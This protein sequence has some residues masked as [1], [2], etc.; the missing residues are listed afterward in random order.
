MYYKYIIIYVL[1]IYIYHNGWPYHSEASIARL[2][3]V[4]PEPEAPAAPAA[5]RLRRPSS[6]AR[7]WRITGFCGFFIIYHYYHY[8]YWKSQ[9]LMGKPTINGHFQ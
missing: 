9:F 3:Q 5:P 6:Q 4:E 1:Y 2:V 7:P 8:S